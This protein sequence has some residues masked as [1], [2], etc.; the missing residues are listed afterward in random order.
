[1]IM[2]VKPFEW[3]CSKAGLDGA[4]QR[5]GFMESPVHFVSPSLQVSHDP[6]QSAHEVKYL[7]TEEQARQIEDLLSL[8]LIPDPHSLRGTNGYSTVTVYCDTP[9]LDVYH[10]RGRNARRKF[11][12]R[13]Y[14]HSETVFVER[15]AKRGSR[16]QKRRSSLEVEQLSRLALPLDQS[17]WAAD[18]FH[19]RVAIRKLNP[20]VAVMYDRAAYVGE[21]SEGPM[22]LT[23][24]RSIRAVAVS[25][26]SVAPFT[27][28]K[29]ILSDW[30]ICEF[31][32]RGA[33]PQPFKSVVE[34]MKLSPGK[35]SKYRL[36]V[37]AVGLS[38]PRSDGNA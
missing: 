23:F 2:N 14:G 34:T 38:N 20:V 30:V 28:G 29:A 11:R 7:V 35:A 17:V 9:E 37:D 8:H 6:D 10:R 25:E 24:D 1:M 21:S 15:K 27:G 16:V 31:K 5:H 4:I 33:M 36:S 32:F 26:W 19:R 22:R 12:I 3:D 18:W 13:R